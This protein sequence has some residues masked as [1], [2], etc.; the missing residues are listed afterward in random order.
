MV[1]AAVILFV[2]CLLFLMVIIVRGE[3]PKPTE[4]PKGDKNAK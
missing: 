4:A 2:L 1:A 3:K